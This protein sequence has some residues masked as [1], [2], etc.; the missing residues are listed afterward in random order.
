[1]SCSSPGRKEV[2][3]AAPCSPGNSRRG[4]PSQRAPAAGGTVGMQLGAPPHTN[5]Q[6]AHT[7][8]FSSLYFIV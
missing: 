1:M 8:S 3:T 2:E 7:S 5:G 4:A 6:G